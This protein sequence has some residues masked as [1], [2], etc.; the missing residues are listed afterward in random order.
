MSPSGSCHLYLLQ[1][2]PSS[3]PG[4]LSGSKSGLVC[5]TFCSPAPGAGFHHSVGNQALT[6]SWNHTPLE[7]FHT[8]NNVLLMLTQVHHHCSALI[9]PLSG[10]HG[11]PSPVLPTE[12]TKEQKEWRELSHPTNHCPPPL[13][14]GHRS[15]GNQLMAGRG[16]RSVISE[17]CG[18]PSR[19]SPFLSCK[20]VGGRSAR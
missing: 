8:A 5:L 20:Y 19:N 4:I 15:C 16:A 13:R 14:E 17:R 3:L 7:L 10:I 6:N 12:A 18:H 1:S 9:A 11:S 2:L